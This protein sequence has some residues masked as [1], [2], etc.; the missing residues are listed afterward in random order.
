MVPNS[1]KMMMDVQESLA[2][3]APV[4]IV[5]MEIEKMPEEELDRMIQLAAEEDD[6]EEIEDA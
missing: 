3:S 1:P 6:E 5:E 4:A 2:A